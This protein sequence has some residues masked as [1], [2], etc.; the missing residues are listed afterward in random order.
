[1]NPA[2]AGIP[3]PVAETLRFLRATLPPPPARLLEV[4]AGDGALAERL[5][6]AGYAI[7]ALDRSADAAAAARARGVEAVAADFLDYRT[8]P[9]DAVLF[10]RSLHHIARLT[11]A[12]DRAHDLLVPEGV[13]AVEDFA[14]DHADRAAVAWLARHETRLRA[15]GLLP[16]D[17][18]PLLPGDPLAG[19]IAHHREKHTVYPGDVMIAALGRR[20]RLER[21]ATAPYLYRYLCTRI[22]PESR[23]AVSRELL[24]EECRLIAAGR[25]PAIGLRVVARPRDRGGR[26]GLAGR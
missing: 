1:M 22:V 7:V 16:I 2:E 17:E 6:E 15:S 4:G 26:T 12:V 21:V 3:V 14:F 24:D 19:W 18:D 11:A 10:T 20:F 8:A 9:F 5:V 25:I 13:L 23:M